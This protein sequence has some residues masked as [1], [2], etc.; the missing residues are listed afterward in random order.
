MKYKIFVYIIPLALMMQPPAFPQAQ[1]EELTTEQKL[2][3]VMH[4]ISSLTLYH[5]VE[6]LASE[7]YGGRLTGTEGFYKS[8]QRVSR[9]FEKWGLIPAGDNNTY[10]QAFPNPYTLV[11]E[12]CYLHMHIP[13]QGDTVIKDYRY[14]EEFIPGS[15]SGSGKVTAEVVYVGYGISAPELGFDEYA[16]VDVKGKIVLME[17][18]APVNPYQDPEVFMDWRPYS[19]H[20]YKL[21]NAAAHGAKGMIYNYHITNPNNAYIEDFI[22]THIGEAVVRDIFAGTGKE[23]KNVVKSI[24]SSLKPQSFPTGKNFTIKNTTEHHPEGIGYNVLAAIP[25]SGREMKNEV[26]LIGGHLDHLGRCYEMMPGANDNASGVAVMMGLAEALMKS[27]VRPKR[28][29]LFNCFGAEEQGVAG[30]DYYVKNPVY[31]LKNTLCLINMDGVGAGDKLSVL[32]AENYPDLWNFLKS[33]NDK[34]VHRLMIP[35]SF[36][37]IARPRLDAARFLWAGVP[38]VSISAFG[39][40]S[41]YH[42]TKDNLDIITPDIMKDL[43]GILFYSVLEMANQKNLSFGEGE[44]NQ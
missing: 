26:I 32:A 42:V 44:Q 36:L 31:P 11:F 2:L 37:N 8:A 4:S 40:P 17:P 3:Q 24:R 30:S 20:Q 12:D 25:G 35:R 39:T 9:H 15:T 1:A 23:H 16:G 7:K 19:F 5:Y 13:V 38:S 14:E 22:Y 10:L 41:Y 29:I 18:E 34:Y 43:A 6:E 33:A 27:P 21:K 28:T